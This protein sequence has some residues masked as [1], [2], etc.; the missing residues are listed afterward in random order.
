[1]GI[2]AITVAICGTVLYHVLNRLIDPRLPTEVS[3]LATYIAAV[4]VVVVAACG[5]IGLEQT[6][7]LLAEASWPSY[8]LG[9][10]VAAVEGGFLLAYRSGWPISAA[11]LVVGTSVAAILVVVGLGVFGESLSLRGSAGITLAML[12][13]ALLTLE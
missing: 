1:M 7:T 10:A 3:L 12:G 9:G 5:R 2:M 8:A 13:V 11:S 6:M 4:G